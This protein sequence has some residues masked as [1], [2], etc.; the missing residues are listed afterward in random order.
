[1]VSVLVN[2]VKKNYEWHEMIKAGSKGLQFEMNY[3]NFENLIGSLTSFGL[4]S[5]LCPAQSQLV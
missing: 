1:M 3:Y 5:E 4:L 2:L